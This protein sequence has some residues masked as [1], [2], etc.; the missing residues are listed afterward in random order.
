MRDVLL[1]WLDWLLMNGGDGGSNYDVVSGR[2]SIAI[3][4]LHLLRS[5]LRLNEINFLL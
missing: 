3:L 2:F 4:P 1:L 5:A